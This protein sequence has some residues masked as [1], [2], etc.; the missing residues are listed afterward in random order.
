MATHRFNCY[1]VLLAFCALSATSR[2]GLRASAASFLSAVSPQAINAFPGK[3]RVLLQRK[4]VA[5]RVRCFAPIQL[6]PRP[7]RRPSSVFCP[8]SSVLHPCSSV[9]IRVRFLFAFVSSCLRGQNPLNLRN[10]RFLFLLVI[11]TF[12]FRYCL[13]FRASYFEFPLLCNL[14]GKKFT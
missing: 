1:G 14:C 13:G 5:R 10:P 11:R 9:S 7:R 3:W 6:S 12:E 4:H 2:M 8:L